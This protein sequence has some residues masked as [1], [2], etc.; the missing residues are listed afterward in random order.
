MSYL[1]A[2][3]YQRSSTNHNKQAMIKLMG[4]VQ[5]ALSLAV[6]GWTLATLSTKK[7]PAI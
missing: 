5:L 1:T 7:N 3:E 4:A 2:P 6:P